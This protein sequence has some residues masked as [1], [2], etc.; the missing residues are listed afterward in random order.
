M[1]CRLGNTGYYFLF[2]FWMWSEFPFKFLSLKLNYWCFFSNIMKLKS[3]T[4]VLAMCIKRLAFQVV[5]HA[6][7]LMGIYDGK[8]I[9]SWVTKTCISQVSLPS[10]ISVS[11]FYVKNNILPGML[12]P[13]GENSKEKSGK[14]MREIL[15][16]L[17]IHLSWG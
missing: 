17:L 15:E 9:S 11:C 16:C 3:Q 13:P 5:V 6:K 14:F 10:K 2:V 8:N 4:F 7:A 1:S 12:P